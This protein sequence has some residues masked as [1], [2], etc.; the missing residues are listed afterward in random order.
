MEKEIKKP[1]L[2]K[3]VVICLVIAS[4]LIISAIFIA[5]ISRED[6]ISSTGSVDDQLNESDSSETFFPFLI[7]FNDNEEEGTETEEGGT[8][9]AID[10]FG[11]GML[12]IPSLIWMIVIGFIVYMILFRRR[13]LF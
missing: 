10:L 7:T 3:R 9:T 5:I 2:S 13:R 8:K 12:G 4:F 1:I 6:G 11:D